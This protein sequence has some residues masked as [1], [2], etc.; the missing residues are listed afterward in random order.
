MKVAPIEKWQYNFLLG[1]QK[2]SQ[3]YYIRYSTYDRDSKIY[4]ELG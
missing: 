4:S 1:I 3:Y 2:W